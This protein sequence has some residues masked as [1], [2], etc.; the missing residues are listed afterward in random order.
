MPSGVKCCSNLDERY[1][2]LQH[3]YRLQ[4]QAIGSTQLCAAEYLTL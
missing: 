2:L 3:L 1:G 4:S